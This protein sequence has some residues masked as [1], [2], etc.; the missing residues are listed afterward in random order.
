MDSNELG[1]D[2]YILKHLPLVPATLCCA[3]YSA[4][5][6]VSQPFTPW[7][8]VVWAMGTVEEPCLPPLLSIPFY[9][10]YSGYIFIWVGYICTKIYSVITKIT[11]NIY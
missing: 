9:A 10:G 7:W 1:T 6:L 4:I 11:Y 5:P 8:G 3:N 2:N